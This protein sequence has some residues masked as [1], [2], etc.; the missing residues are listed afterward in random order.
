MRVLLCFV[1]QLCHYTTHSS[2]WQAE[3]P[4]EGDD[5]EDFVE[6]TL[7]RKTRQN[8]RKMTSFGGDTAKL[9][10]W[11]GRELGG[12]APHQCR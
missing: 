11:V 7:P 5:F 6:Y 9:A 2:V 4:F 10:A 8:G 12:S 1:D 3:I